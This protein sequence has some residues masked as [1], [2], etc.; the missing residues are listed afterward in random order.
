M[1]V[2][3]RN[4]TDYLSA[5][6]RHKI[7]V[8][9]TTIIAI[10]FA[11]AVSLTTTKE[12]TASAQMQLLSQNQSTYNGSV[13]PLSATDIATGVQ[14]AT[15]TQVQK[16][17]SKHLGH[18]APPATA[19][20]VGQT[21]VVEIS[22]SS[23]HPV[24]AA[25]VANLYVQSYI[26]YTQQRFSGQVAAQESV[27]EQKRTN[28]QAQIAQVESEIAALPEKSPAAT[29][30]NLE[31]QTLSSQLQ[32]VTANLTQLELSLETISSGAQSTSAAIPPTTPSSP[33]TLTNTAA[34]GLIGLVLGIGATFI[35]DYFDDKIRDKNRLISASDGLPVLADIPAFEQWSE[36][37]KYKIL[38][39]ERPNSIAAEAYRSLRTSIQFIGLDTSD[40]KVILVTSPNDSEGK[41]TTAVNLGATLAV[42]GLRTI[43][44]GG[45]LR[46][47]EVHKYFSLVNDKGLS[48][49]LAN[50][51]SLEDATFTY[52]PLPNLSILP[53]GPIPPNPS[54]LLGSKRMDDILAALKGTYDLVIIDCPPVLPITDTVI[55]TQS[56]DASIV[57]AKAGAT[58]ARAIAEA[59]SRLRAVG[60]KLEGTV[61]NSTELGS[62]GYRYRYRYRYGAYRYESAYSSNPKR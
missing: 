27:L 42:G 41:T 22:V 45:D 44:V 47:P 7:V 37:D 8:L 5:I 12:Y 43:L 32:T 30:L 11:L 2:E 3:E 55:L 57:I 60:G 21:A 49:V 62:G 33:K 61:I 6:S 10:V 35:I 16:L 40:T 29:A 4:I 53:S 9:V 56:A 18:P 26:E 25:R 20:E 58:H 59:V 1:Q 52:E 39:L 17:V 34:A 15:S 51:V 38:S 14:V 31:L 54:E 28:L 48:S 24:Y 46:R 13:V 23:P 50:S 19:T 36:E